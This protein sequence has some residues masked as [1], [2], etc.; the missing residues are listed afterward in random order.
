MTMTTHFEKLNNNEYQSLKDAHAL[1]ALYIAGADGTID[2]GEMEWAK[3]I[4]QIRS[5]KMSE[6][7]LPY[8][9][10]VD[11]E[12][13]DK[14][15]SILTGLSSDALTRKQQI[16]SKLAGLNSI[17]AKLEPS[18]GAHL[19]KAFVTFASHVA[20]ATGGF[21]GFFSVSGNEKALLNLS[22]IDPII[23]EEEEEE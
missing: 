15:N 4:T 18:V 12:F 1:I 8:Y 23:V 16:E 22:M 11:I 17:M 20:K 6:D 21:F 10:E 14:V 9:E 3:K 13:T 7:L 5:Y 19:Y 2:K